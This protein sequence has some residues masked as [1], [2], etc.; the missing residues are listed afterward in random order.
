[1]LPHHYIFCRLESSKL[2]N[3]L[4]DG[5]AA[6]AQQ[7]LLEV[8]ETEAFDLF[9]LSNQDLKDTCNQLHQAL[10]T[11]LCAAHDAVDE[12]WLPP[13]MQAS[14]RVAVSHFGISMDQAGVW[15]YSACNWRT[16]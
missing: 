10:Y 4:V 16:A 13:A 7:K 3:E 14:A 9:T 15:V 2:V 6:S 11:E 8:L 12:M 5:S 1:M